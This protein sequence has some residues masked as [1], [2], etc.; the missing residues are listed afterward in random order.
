MQAL[1]LSVE[2]LVKQEI[3]EN[4]YQLSGKFRIDLKKI[5][6]SA[7]PNQYC[8]GIPKQILSVF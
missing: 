2:N 8:L 5:L 7:M 4:S 1:G 6:G 3:F